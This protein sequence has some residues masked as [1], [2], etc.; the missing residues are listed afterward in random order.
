[1][2]ARQLEFRIDWGYQFLYSRRH[3]HPEY[4]WDGRIECSGGK[5]NAVVQLTYPVLWWGPVQSPQETPLPGAEWQS[6]TR[7]GLAGVRVMAD[8]AENAEFKLVTDQGAFTFSAR[9]IMREGRIVFPVGWKYSHC[10]VI[11]TRQGFYW[12]RP[13]PLAL[14]TVVAPM[15]LAGVDVVDW[16]RMQQAWLDAGAGA[17]FNLTLP[18]S[19]EEGENFWLF[20]LQVMTAAKRGRPETQASDYMPMELC[21][22]DRPVAKV[23]YYLRE[24]DRGVEV[25]HDV[26]A[27]IPFETLPPG[28]HR[29]RLLNC[30]AKLPLLV[31]RISFRPKTRRH[32]DLSAPAWALVGREFIVRL[33]TLVPATAVR[34]DYDRS[35]FRSVTVPNPDS[36]LAVGLHEI[37][38]IP[39]LPRRTAMIRARDLKTGK[40]TTATVGAIYDLQPEL[41]EVKVGFDM[42]T[43]PH[44]DTGAMD[45]I[46]D[47]THRTQLGNLVV[48]RPFTPKPIPGNLMERW[49][50]FCRDHGIYVQAVHAFEDG[51]IAA[52]AGEFFQGLGGHEL[53]G[54]T[55]FCD[56]DNVSCTM[57]EAAERYSAYIRA[58][59]EKHRGLG[60]K[61]SYG[62]ASG[63]HRYSLLAG[64]DFMRAETMVQHTTQHLSQA[65]P[66]AQA[67]GNGEWG[68]HIAIQHCK[69]PYLE[70]H[71]G[72]YYLSLLQP[73]IM[74]ASFLYEEDS[75]FLLFK[76]ERQCWNDVLTKGKRDMTRAFFRFAQTHPRI[77]SPE[78]RSGM[79]LGRYAPPFNGFI[80]GKEQ[81]PSYSVWGKFG[82]NEPAW[83]H[84]Q[85]EKGQH[86]M[87]V[88]MPGASTH[89]LRQRYDRRRFFF[90][91]SPYGDFDQVPIE[92]GADFLSRYKLLLH[93][94]WN[95]MIPEDYAK[96]K[97]YVQNGG[98]LF[99]GVPQLSMH[100]DRDFL[101][102][103]DDLALY[104][105]GHVADLCGV[106]ILGRGA[107][108]SGHW[109]PTSEAFRNAVAPQLARTPSVAP[110]EDG[111]CHL[112]EVELRGAQPVIVDALHRK[113][114]L[115][116][117]ALGRG[118][119]YLL[120]TW[121]YPGHEELAHLSAAVVARLGAM[122]RGACRIED[123]ACETF[124][125]HWPSG[126][127]CGRLMLLNTDWTERAGLQPVTVRTPAVT[128]TTAVRER[129]V[130]IITYLPFGVL[131]PEDPEPHV[132][133]VE[134][135]ARFAR[136][137]I[138]ATGRHGFRFYAA[139]PAINVTA[140]GRPV[141]LIGVCPRD[142]L[143]WKLT[144]DQVTVTE[145]VIA[146]RE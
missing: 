137:R 119:V 63:A 18:E 81:D 128:F 26:W 109:I 144:W 53:S 11:V 37:R 103:M 29:L 131:V 85:P 61:I 112:A 113:P 120:T 49:G 79:I 65:R 105:G 82:R 99:L 21:L 60:Q 78:V 75:L 74:G 70:S 3:Y 44:D 76:E 54:A 14:E 125:T 83:G 69:Q 2:P 84:R 143:T 133:I 7:R 52:G 90:S 56:P 43:V 122:H 13:A 87:D 139:V 107:R 10:T 48:F 55:Y 68:V 6:T 135:D 25:L 24:H 16:A 117:Y 51:R 71:L 102:R 67:L 64:A 95:T 66:A 30:H 111:P 9:Q 8:C 57:K 47:Y 50:R 32:L 1:M 58:D 124:W 35:V 89:P 108:Y 38:L 106:N 130:S 129:Q 45:W 134:A 33:R 140:A 72:W 92:A 138:H 36:P 93:L 28:R 115:V 31:N 132:E 41:P 34:L 127:D 142:G 126:R 88:L 101:E 136:L 22:G 118:W 98:T 77:G 141:P 4:C 12:F 42:T 5:I 23:R 116:K 114:L 96:L 59:I 121:A 146:V 27:E 17:D 20:H 94:C 123:P 80:C 145:C 104:A 62:D 86:V 15:D 40:E 97:T 19:R 91:G 110:D 100:A 46:L 39:L 73:W